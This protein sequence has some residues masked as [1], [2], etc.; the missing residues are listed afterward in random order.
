MLCCCLFVF[1]RGV[2]TDSLPSNALAIHVTLVSPYGCSSR[3][4][5]RCITTPCF[6]GFC[7]WSHFPM[8]QFLHGDHFRTATSTPY[9]RAL[10]PSSSLIGF[11]TDQVLSIIHLIFLMGQNCPE[12]PVLP[13]FRLL[14]STRSLFSFRRGWPLHKVH[15]LIIRNPL[16]IPFARFTNSKFRVFL[17]VL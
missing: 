8:A 15:F 2:F 6:L 7:S 4:A 9:L 12:W 17:R 10:V 11:Q 5:N 16:S 3:K 14:L 13:H 1:G